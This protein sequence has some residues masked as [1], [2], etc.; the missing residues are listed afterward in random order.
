MYAAS[1]RVPREVF[2]DFDQ[3]QR[4]LAQAFSRPRATRLRAASLSAFP[5]VNVGS[6][7][8]AV[9]VQVFVPGIDPDALDVTVDK[10]VLTISGERPSSLAQAGEG[11]TVHARERASGGFR[12]V[13][14]LPEDVDAER[15]EARYQDGVLHIAIPRR[16]AAKPR[17]IE[18]RNA[19]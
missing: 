19:H 15:I 8:E 1:L 16:E 10:G 4:Q 5:A 9:Q 6:T 18:V 3:L 11:L 2:S 12:R 17:R 13:V 14:N 7:A